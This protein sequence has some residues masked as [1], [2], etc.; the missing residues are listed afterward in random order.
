MRLATQLR[1]ERWQQQYVHLIHIQLIYGENEWTMR[2]FQ[3]QELCRDAS[4]T[5]AALADEKGRNRQD[6]SMMRC[7]HHHQH[8]RN[9]L[10]WK[11]LLPS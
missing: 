9:L 8:L 7:V 1:A 4:T 6:L 11:T 10:I 2:G 3:R 5:A